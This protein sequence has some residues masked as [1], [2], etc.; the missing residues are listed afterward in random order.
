MYLWLI[1]AYFAVALVW[2]IAFALA[3]EALR[4]KGAARDAK[5]A[6]SFG[7]ACLVWPVV[8]VY[9]TLVSLVKIFAAP[10]T[11]NRKI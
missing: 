2:F 1:I 9:V 6:N 10:F 8:I 7:C 3:Y 4:K 5:L 11:K